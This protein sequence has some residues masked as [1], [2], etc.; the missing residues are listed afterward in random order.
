MTLMER[1]SDAYSALL[2]ALRVSHH[3]EEER[4]HRHEQILAATHRAT[5]VPLE[6]IRAAAAALHTSIVVAENGAR[7]AS[8][9]VAAAVE[10]LSGAVRAACHS[11]DSNLA[12]LKDGDYVARV[13]AERLRLEHQSDT[14]AAHA[15]Q[16]LATA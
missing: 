16:A 5:D 14:D 15:R 1:D 7:T 3:S 2:A 10:L 9:D 4:A 11:V 13:T 6:T 12:A 8:G